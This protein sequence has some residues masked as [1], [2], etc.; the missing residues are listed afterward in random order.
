[1]KTAH[2]FLGLLLFFLGTALQAQ[3]FWTGPKVKFSK[4]NF[5]DWTLEAN[6]DRI[7]DS[8]WITRADRS[9]IFNIAREAGFNRESRSSPIGTEWAVGQIADG[10]ENLEFTTWVATNSNPPPEELN[11][12]KVL[13]LIEEDIYID[14]K[15]T[16]WTPGGGGSG[17]GMGGGFAYE[18]SSP[19]PDTDNDGDGFDATEDCNDNNPEVNP[20]QDEIP[21]NGLDD[22]CNPDTRDDDLDGDGFVAADDCNDGDA[23]INPDQTEI[24]FNGLDD[25]CNPN[26]L[27]DD[28]DQDGYNTD[29]DCNDND[30][31]INPGQSEIPY[32]GIDDDCNPN[33]R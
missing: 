17:T 4:A 28:A 11:I 8:V 24:P 19:G 33:T 2:C 7:T 21:Y 16:A 5:A 31:N 23:M 25:D 14:I 9:G 32:N 29:S 30:P 18:R 13:H 12:N 20:D 26:T 1:M 22:D 3:T 27:D 15:F 6:Q 10:I